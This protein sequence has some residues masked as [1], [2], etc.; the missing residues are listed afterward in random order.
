MI[1][2]LKTL[3]SALSI[4]PPRAPNQMSSDTGQL[5]SFLLTVSKGHSILMD[6]LPI[7]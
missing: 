5:R 2:V 6:T 4:L 3:S 1:K 7:Q